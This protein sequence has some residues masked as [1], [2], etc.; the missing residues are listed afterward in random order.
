MLIDSLNKLYA[1][2]SQFDE[3]KPIIVTFDKSNYELSFHQLGKTVIAG[4]ISNMF[5]NKHKVR[6]G[7]LTQLG[8]NRLRKN[9]M[10]LIAMQEVHDGIITTHIN[11]LGI[12][13]YKLIRTN[14][15]S[16]LSEVVRLKFINITN[17]LMVWIVCKFYSPETY[18]LYK[19][20]KNDTKR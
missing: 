9:I 13:F 3:S 18:T 6:I 20:I 16:G 10:D 19:L 15:Y 8:A 2:L 11:D 1:D 7:I 4:Y 5:F 17:S 12:S 14:T